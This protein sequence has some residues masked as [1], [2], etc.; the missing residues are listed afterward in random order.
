[1]TQRAAPAN[2]R[3]MQ[4]AS[5]SW[6]ALSLAVIVLMGCT[7]GDAQP[8]GP[9]LP[10]GGTLRVGII[11]TNSC[12]LTLCGTWRFDPQIGYDNITY[13]LG[14]CCL[15]R[16]L[17]SFNGQ[18]T[19][20]GGGI[21]RPDLAE[22]LPDIS[23]DGLTWTFRLRPGLRYG[24]PL[25]DTPI[26]SQDIV[27]S[28]ESLLSPRPEML[29]EDWGDIHDYYLGEFL[30]MGGIIEGARDYI[31]G[32]TDRIPGLE[33]PDDRTLVVHVTE[34]TGTLGYLLAFPDTAP[35]PENP[36]DPSARFGIA[37]GQGRLFGRYVASSGPYMVEGAENLDYS[38]PPDEWQQ[39]SGDAADTYTLVRNPSWNREIDPLRPAELDRIVISRVAGPKEAI[40]QVSSGAL[41]VIWDWVNGKEVGFGATPTAGSGTLLERSSQD[42]VRFL[43][44]NV[45]VPPLD[46]LNV[47]RAISFA[48]DRP[49]ISQAFSSAGSVPNRVTTHVGLNSEENNLL[50]GYDPFD[51]ATGP[52]LRAA[53]AEMAKSAYDRDGDGRCDDCPPIRLVVPDYDPA[54]VEAADL[55]A[56]DLEEIGLRVR[57]DVLHADSF[58]RLYTNPQAHV[59]MRLDSWYKD[60][61][62]AATWFPL[63]FG[64]TDLGL[65][66]GGNVYMVGASER[67]LERWGYDVTS[68]PS[69]DD[70]IDACLGQAFEAQ[71]RCWAELDTYITERVVSWVP[72]IEAS[73]YT[74]VS[75]RV[76]RFS[77]D[78][79]A[80]TPIAALDQL[81]VGPEPSVAP[82]SPVADTYP[83]IPAGVYR[84]TVTAADL[85]R[86]GVTDPPP[87]DVR[88]STGT[89]TM[90]LGEGRWYFTQR[91]DHQ[92]TGVLSVVGTYAG[93][94][95]VARFTVEANAENAIELPPMRWRVDGDGA[96]RFTMRCTADDPPFCPYLRAQYAARPWQ[97]V[98]TGGI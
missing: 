6:L 32:L 23:P 53:R 55:I 16:S 37:T 51:A 10:S 69:V 14:R 7:R 13:E 31:G 73:G 1:M 86:S 46:D 3:G 39:P 85:R 92:V 67:Q 11:D 44:L 52:N 8:T 78:Q 29:P 72:L 36:F 95:R 19:A 33:T 97:P 48:V 20:G 12:P 9:A 77:V 96:L 68:V 27:R 60:G 91:A 50:L 24:P 63:L 34:P 76:S 70:R 35:I 79:S 25:G 45:A 2:D 88:N 57:P 58:Y 43:G 42:N 18:S 26:R 4:H 59:A 54:R 5:R 30:D 41:D 38:L 49:A 17:L 87:E 62:T 64:G 21:L 66:S 81:A 40:E 56:A 65:I 90:V 22:S 82:A 75:A 61:S 74:P 28:I 47:R 71:L 15:L 83:D 89:F 84:M 80:A 94:G 93:S 98:P